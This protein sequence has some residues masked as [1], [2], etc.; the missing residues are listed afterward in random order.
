MP[1]DINITIK[2]T[3]VT[4]NVIELDVAAKITIVSKDFFNC[5]YHFIVLFLFLDL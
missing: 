4:D 3:P 1:V 2:P 5:G